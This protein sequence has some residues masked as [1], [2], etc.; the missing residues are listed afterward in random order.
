MKEIHKREGF[1]FIASR[2]SSHIFG[3]IP[4]LH[5]HTLGPV[6]NLDCFENHTYQYRGTFQRRKLNLVPDLRV[7]ISSV[8]VELRIADLWA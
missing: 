2:P 6:Y 8:I 4:Y 3:K 1:I 7:H 5:F